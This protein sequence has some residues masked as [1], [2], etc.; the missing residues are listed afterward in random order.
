MPPARGSGLR[1][2]VAGG[3]YLESPRWHGDYL[4]M[5][6]SLARMILRL[7]AT[8]DCEKV[9][10]VEGVPGGLGVRSTGEVVVVSMFKGMLL[11]YRA[12]HLTTLADLRAVAAGTLDDMIIDGQGRAYVGDLGFDLRRP[13]TGA[14]GRVILVPREGTSPRVVA[15]GLRF[16]NGLAV[17]GDGKQLLVAE[18]AGDCLVRFDIEDDGSLLF[19]GRFGRLGEPDGICMDREGCVWVS[20]FKEDA[21]ARVDGAGRVLERVSTPGRRAVACALGGQDRRTLF[22]LSAETTHEDLRSGRS[23][24]QV[25][26]VEVEVPGAGFP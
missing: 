8:G 26:A 18:S 4:W 9:C 23:R 12:G 21:F 2:L 22:C 1:T 15:E 3:R 13:A 5:V 24:A 7:R 16:P 10:D 19:R 20:L 6:D 25:D 14:L 17:S 11:E